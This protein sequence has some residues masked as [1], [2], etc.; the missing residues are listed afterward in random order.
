MTPS[1]PMPSGPDAEGWGDHSWAQA[2]EFAAPARSS[3]AGP[4]RPA[5]TLSPERPLPPSRPSTGTQTNPDD[6][7]DRDARAAADL[8]RAPG[9]K[10]TAEPGRSAATARHRGLS[11]PVALLFLVAFLAGG[12]AV[13]QI[14]GFGGGL[15]IGLIVGSLAAVLL[16]RLRSLFA[17]V[18]APPLAF[19]AGSAAELIVK[20]GGVPKRTDLLGFATGWLV[21]GFPTIA[22]ASAAVLVVAGARWALGRKSA[23]SAPLVGRRAAATA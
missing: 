8:D 10:Q 14:A 21:Y 11:A 18:V 6:A 1:V 5:A 2:P 17:V 23:G 12:I 13:D 4:P 15:R 19:M 16:V 7:Y 22:I 3:H 9:R 20:S